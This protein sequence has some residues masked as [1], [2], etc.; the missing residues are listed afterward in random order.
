MIPLYLVRSNHLP[1]PIMDTDK[2]EP[3]KLLQIRR[4]YA[5]HSLD[6]MILILRH[7]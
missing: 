2:R 4:K 5:D 1:L 6:R 3:E 7:A